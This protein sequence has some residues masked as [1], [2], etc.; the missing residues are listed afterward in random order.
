MKP[1]NLSGSIARRNGISSF[2]RVSLSTFPVGKGGGEILTPYKAP[3]ES[4][5]QISIQVLLRAGS[6]PPVEKAFS[7]HAGSD[8]IVGNDGIGAIMGSSDMEMGQGCLRV[9][10]RNG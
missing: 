5:I 4:N 9:A 2:S 3:K 7:Y 1:G 10:I 6:K 8:R